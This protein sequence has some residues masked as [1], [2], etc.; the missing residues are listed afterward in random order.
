MEINDILLEW[1]YR[2]KK[3]YPTMEDGKFTDPSEL[4]VLHEILKENGINEMPSFVKSKTPVSDVIKHSVINEVDKDSITAA[5]VEKVFKDRLKAV[6]ALSVQLDDGS[7]DPEIEDDI[8][9]KLY[10]LHQDLQAFT[11]YDPLKKT[12]KLTGFKEKI[13][14][15][16]NVVY[17]MPKKIS[18]EIQEMLKALPSSVYSKF[19]SYLDKKGKGEQEYFNP[20]SHYGNFKKDLAET[21][22][23]DE[24]VDILSKYT[25]QDEGVKGVGMAEI[26]MAL[27]YQN[28]RKPKGAGDLELDKVG[29]LEV[30]GWSARLGASGGVN[31]I[32]NQ[33]FIKRLNEIGIT[34]S[35]GKVQEDALEEGTRIM[36]NDKSLTA[37]F[38]LAKAAEDGN[39]AEVEALVVDMMK[40]TNLIPPSNITCNWKDPLEV[41]RYWGLGNLIKYYNGLKSKFVGFIACDAGK[42]DAPSNGDYIYAKGSINDIVDYLWSQECGFEVFNLS[43][44]LLPRIEYKAAPQKESEVSKEE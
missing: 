7:L 3:G 9:G 39:E 25:G 18:L 12:F 40:A 2:L 30:K 5:D 8:K 29:E 10:R 33:D 1:S 4:K 37:P 16:G 14:K 36:Y 43:S 26:M 28:I 19:I 27:L 13:D 44:N 24:L 15:K 34:V 41:N 32:T 21:G 11:L 35:G 6:K 20:E 31:L 22:M 38:A 17:N 23:T 42:K